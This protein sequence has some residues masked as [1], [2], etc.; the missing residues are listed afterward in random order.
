MSNGILDQI[1]HIIEVEFPPDTFPYRCHCL[2]N[3]L[4]FL[5]LV[6]SS[7]LICG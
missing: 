2:R 5:Y 4:F 6:R 3:K 7:I 1:G